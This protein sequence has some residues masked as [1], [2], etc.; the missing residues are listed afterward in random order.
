MKWLYLLPLLQLSLLTAQEKPDIPEATQDRVAEVSASDSFRESLRKATEV[1]P[2]E[3]LPDATR[4]PQLFEK[5]L[6]DLRTN[7]ALNPTRVAGQLVYPFSEPYRVEREYDTWI[8][9][10]TDPAGIHQLESEKKLPD[11]HA[12]NL[13]SWKSGKSKF[14]ALISFRLKQIVFARDGERLRYQLKPKTYQALVDHFRHTRRFRPDAQ[15]EA[16]RFLDAL[17]SS[18]KVSAYEGT[19]RPNLGDPTNAKKTRGTFVLDGYEFFKAGTPERDTKKLKS[20][21]AAKDSIIEWRGI[22]A[23]GGFHP[24]LCITWGPEYNKSR[25]LICLTCHEVKIEDAASSL[26]FDIGGHVYEE[27]KAEVEQFR[28]VAK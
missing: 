28:A 10:L 4:H 8:E 1:T 14:H 19:P 24:D 26:L 9:A 11:F 12:E 17:E 27:L 18:S 7:M 3:A 20:I 15:E 13:I 5:E 23:C 22:K 6:K 21:L 16:R 25:I 2:Y